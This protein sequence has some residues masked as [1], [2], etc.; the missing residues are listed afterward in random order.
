MH[1]LLFLSTQEAGEG[2]GSTYGYAK[3]A[4]GV[5]WG[6][7]GWG[8]T[9]FFANV[10]STE[11]L[12][13]KTAPTASPDAAIFCHQKFVPTQWN[14]ISL[15]QSPKIGPD[16]AKRSNRKSRAFKRRFTSRKESY[17]HR[18]REKVQKENKRQHFL[19]HG[20]PPSKVHGVEWTASEQTQA[21]EVT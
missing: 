3:E 14:A 11:Q 12:G 6:W 2:N 15:V 13:S 21:F 7:N 4:W 5:G 8:L 20:K 16:A 1:R 17:V 10:Q 19:L 9:R 18:R